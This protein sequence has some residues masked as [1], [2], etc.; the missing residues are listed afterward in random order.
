VRTAI[1]T[2][3]TGITE[4]RVD[5]TPFRSGQKSACQFC[6][7]KPVCQFDPEQAGNSYHWLR[8]GGNDEWWTRMEIAAAK[9]GG[10]LDD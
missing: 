4:G 2:I 1:R 9:E 5:I 7:Y 3:G 8:S 6:A 10:E